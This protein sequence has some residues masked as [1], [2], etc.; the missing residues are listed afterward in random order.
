MTLFSFFINFFIRLPLHVALA[1]H[2][3]PVFAFPR[4]LHHSFYSLPASASSYFMCACVY[5]VCVLCRTLRCVQQ[6]C[7]TTPPDAFI[8][9][10]SCLMLCYVPSALLAISLSPSVGSLPLS[11]SLFLSRSLGCK[12]YSSIPRRYPLALHCSH[13]RCWC[14]KRSDAGSGSGFSLDD[15]NGNSSSSSENMSIH[16]SLYDC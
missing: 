15:D 12:S 7:C 16:A 10:H 1:V 9:E 5:A 11:L 8:I 6:T 3:F 14:S 4:L 2:F 13:Q